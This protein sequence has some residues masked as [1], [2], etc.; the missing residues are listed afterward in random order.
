MKAGA[1]RYAVTGGVVAA[2]L[3]VAV[4]LYARYTTRPWTRDAQVRANV[5]GIAPR[6]AGPVVRV[7]VK[8]NQAV[9]VGDLLFEIDPATFEAAAAAAEARVN[10]AKVAVTKARKIFSRQRDISEKE[11]DGSRDL[12]DAQD[13]VARVETELSAAVAELQ[14]AQLE[15]SSARVTAPVNGYITNLATSPGTYVAA[16][17][18]LLAL[19]DKDSFWIAAYFKETQLAHV[20]VGGTAKIILMGHESDP[21][22]GEI[23]SVGWGVF[24]EDG[25]PAADLLPRV[26]QTVDWVRLPQRFPARVRIEGQPPVPLRI[27]QTASVVVVGD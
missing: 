5:V 1:R 27:G 8:D 24:R 20:R 14:K 12:E 11:V 10:Q 25:A 7:A 18:E 13:A 16:G 21:V 6:V 19:V 22:V 23:E 9:A 17:V 2:A 26:S 15:L 4:F 3:L